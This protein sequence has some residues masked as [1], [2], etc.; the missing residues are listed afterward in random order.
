MSS[1]ASNFKRKR[2]S[3]GDRVQYEFDNGKR[4]NGVIVKITDDLADVLF[5]DNDLGKNLELKD[6]NLSRLPLTFRT[7][8]IDPRTRGIV[9]H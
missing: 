6:P 9:K 8:L 5:D 3:L 7:H 2:C 1:R 4:Y